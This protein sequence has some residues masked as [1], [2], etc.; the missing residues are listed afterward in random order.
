M[1]LLSQREV[2]LVSLKGVNIFSGT[3]WLLWVSNA[4]LFFHLGEGVHGLLKGAQRFSCGKVEAK[5]QTG[6]R[7]AGKCLVPCLPYS[8]N[9]SM[10]AH[11]SIPRPSLTALHSNQPV[12]SATFLVTS[13]FLPALCPSFLS[14]TFTLVHKPSRNQETFCLFCGIVSISFSVSASLFGSVFFLLLIFSLS[15]R[16]L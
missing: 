15:I 8:G 6:H 13:A 10:T 9:S 1:I 7:S 12:C 2:D 11:T 5:R 4:L 3:L 16:L 14:S